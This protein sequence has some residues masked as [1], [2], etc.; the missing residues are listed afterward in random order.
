MGAGWI[1]I[2][3]GTIDDQ[4][5]MGSTNWITKHHHSHD[6]RGETRPSRFG[7]DGH[8]KLVLDSGE[9]NRHDAI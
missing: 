4:E 6:S 9:C 8:R 1:R 2:H 3:E 7:I 5:S